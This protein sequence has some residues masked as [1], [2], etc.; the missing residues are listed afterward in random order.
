MVVSLDWPLQGVDY[1]APSL[2]LPMVVSLDH[3]LQGVDC[4]VSSLRLT[5]T[6]MALHTVEVLL[7]LLVLDQLMPVVQHRNL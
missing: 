1:L 6:A 4:L 7:S 2:H 5:A 3:P